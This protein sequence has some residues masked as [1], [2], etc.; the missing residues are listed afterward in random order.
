MLCVFIYRPF[1]MAV[2]SYAAFYGNIYIYTL[3]YSFRG[4]I[5]VRDL[6]VSLMRNVCSAVFIHVFL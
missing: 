2:T 6:C 3:P 5:L 1:Q 4:M